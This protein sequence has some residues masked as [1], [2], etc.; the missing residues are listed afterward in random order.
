M[1]DPQAPGGGSYPTHSGVAGCVIETTPLSPRITYFNTASFSLYL[2][3]T[4]YRSYRSHTHAYKAL[5]TEPNHD[6]EPDTSKLSVRETAQI[7]A[8]WSI[9]WFVANWAINAALAWTSV[10]SVTILSS[11]SGE[12]AQPGMSTCRS[13]SWVVPSR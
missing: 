11:T 5:N 8:W 7:A 13:R 12:S 2:L 10:A 3:P 9:V 6:D 1:S 4:L